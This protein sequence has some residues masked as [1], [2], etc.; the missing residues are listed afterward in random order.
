MGGATLPSRTAL[1]A[2]GGLVFAS[3]LCAGVP[4]RA[5]ADAKSSAGT[6]LKPGERI[7]GLQ[8]ETAALRADVEA[9]NAQIKSAQ[10][11]EM[12]LQRTLREHTQ[13]S[14][15]AQLGV[16]PEDLDEET[17][18]LYKRMTALMGELA[19]IQTQLR[20]RLE[21]NPA[22]QKNRVSFGELI[23]E[24]RRLRE[25]SNALLSRRGQL[26]QRIATLER[27]VADLRKGSGSAP[28][29]AAEA[30]KP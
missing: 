11:K 23:K 15:W 14:A 3:L 30:P 18:A 22:Y 16:K 29:G 1:L 19:T 24:Q 12:E 10:D 26:L 2:V 4:A 9:V 25:E 28:S 17:A 13:G 20:E 27:Q 8:A 6:D 21:K 7:A 5:A